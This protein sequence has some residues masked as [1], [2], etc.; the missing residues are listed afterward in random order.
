MMLSNRGEN[1]YEKRD[2]VWVSGHQAES[3]DSRG[4]KKFRMKGLKMERG[5]K[6]DRSRA[7]KEAFA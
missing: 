6:E 1:A 2:L 4:T 7:A 3:G 5:T